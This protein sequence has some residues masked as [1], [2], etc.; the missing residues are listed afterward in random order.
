VHTLRSRWR[1]LAVTGLLLVCLGGLS[2]CESKP[3][4]GSQV[5]DSGPIDSEQKAKVKAAYAKTHKPAT[6]PT[7]GRR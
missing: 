2:G 1:S 5:A 4:D 6:K 3:P 7:A